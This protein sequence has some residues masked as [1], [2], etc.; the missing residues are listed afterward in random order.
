M[1]FGHKQERDLAIRTA[2]MGLEGGRYAKRNPSDREGHVPYVS[3]IYGILKK[4]NKNKLV[5]TEDRL[6][7]ARGGG[8]ERSG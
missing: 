3:L 4:I 1:S 7:I 2:W 5:D 8:G 6:V